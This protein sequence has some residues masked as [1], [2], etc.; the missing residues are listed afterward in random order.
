GSVKTS[1]IRCIYFCLASYRQTTINITCK[2]TGP[3]TCP[4]SHCFN[5]QYNSDDSFDHH[6]K[7]TEHF[8]DIRR[9]TNLRVV[10]KTKMN[11]Q[12]AITTT[13]HTVATATEAFHH[14]TTTK[15]MTTSSWITISSSTTV[16]ENLTILYGQFVH[17]AINSTMTEAKSNGTNQ[18]TTSTASGI[19]A[20]TILAFIV[21]L[22]SIAGVLLWCR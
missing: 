22:A 13:P 21:V 9:S 6:G 2:H 11:G 7:N 16:K 17:S 8:Y 18:A 4:T 20:G 14:R 3:H 12:T 5:I 10:V 19:A 15:K 1:A